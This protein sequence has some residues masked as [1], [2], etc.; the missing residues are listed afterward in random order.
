MKLL[1][2]NSNSVFIFYDRDNHKTVQLAPGDSA[3]ITEEGYEKIK[4]AIS[5]ANVT[6]TD[7][8]TDVAPGH[9]VVTTEHDQEVNH[10][11]PIL[12]EDHIMPITNPKDH[13]V[14]VGNVDPA[15]QSVNPD[16]VVAEQLH[17]VTAVPSTAIDAK[18]LS[19]VPTSSAT[20]VAP[21][22]VEHSAPVVATDAVVPAPVETPVVTP[23]ETSTDS[24]TT[25][26]KSKGPK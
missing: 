17:P 15:H 25:D 24:T 21:V 16:T 20:E 3:E 4:D 5:K 26:K 7:Q 22:T 13:A 2:N 8:I 9:V 1:K 19:Q 14:V 23:A 10:K 18:R 11:D 6:V 12:P